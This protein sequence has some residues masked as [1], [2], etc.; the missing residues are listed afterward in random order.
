MPIFHSHLIY[1]NMIAFF[2]VCGYILFLR[3]NKNVFP[4]KIMSSS[5][6]EVLMLLR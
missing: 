3:E 5:G 6:L 2:S 1:E 4:L